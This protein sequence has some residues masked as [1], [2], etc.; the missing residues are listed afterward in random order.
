MRFVRPLLLV[1]IAAVMASCY[2]RRV[3]YQ[4]RPVDVAGWEQGDTLRFQLPELSGSFT[5]TVYARTTSLYPYRNLSLRVVRGSSAVDV[6]LVLADKTG[7][8]EGQKGIAATEVK[9]EVGRVRLSPKDDR[10]IS[11]VHDMRRELLPGISDIGISLD[12]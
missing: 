6:P 3:Y 11:V 2:N 5:L 9:A 12:R 4:F 10:V 7:K 1:A 8:P